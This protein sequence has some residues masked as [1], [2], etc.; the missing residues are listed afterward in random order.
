MKRISESTSKGFMPVPSYLYAASAKYAKLRNELQDHPNGESPDHRVNAAGAPGEKHCPS[1]ED[2]DECHKAGGIEQV[3]Q[4]HPSH[5]DA[6]LRATLLLG[7]ELEAKTMRKVL[8]RALAIRDSEVPDVRPHR[9]AESTIDPITPGTCMI[10]RYLLL[11]PRTLRPLTDIGNALNEWP[12]LIQEDLETQRGVLG[13]DFRLV[14]LQADLESTLADSV[15]EFA[16]VLPMVLAS[17]AAD[18]HWPT[19]QLRIASWDPIQQ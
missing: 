10:D 17:G 6:E 4:Q 16:N 2:P 15:T 19:L 18:S 9:L 5:L 1:G 8:Q 14:Q 3:H 12:I 11:L 7:M 13:Y